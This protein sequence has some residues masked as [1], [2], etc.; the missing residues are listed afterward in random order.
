[1]PTGSLYTNGRKREAILAR[2]EIY[3]IVDASVFE[4]C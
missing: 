4:G 1:M 3:R 2:D